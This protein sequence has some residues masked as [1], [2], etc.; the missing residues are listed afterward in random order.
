M[1]IPINQ[2]LRVSGQNLPAIKAGQSYINFHTVQF[3][4]GEIRG[5]ILAVPAPE[6]GT[7]GLLPLG[8]VALAGVGVARRRKTQAAAP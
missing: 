4:G 6:P 3:T 1:S 7:L 2:M 8:A 5:Q